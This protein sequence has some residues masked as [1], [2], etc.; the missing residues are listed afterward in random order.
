MNAST[1][2][3]DV[4]R[5]IEN[6]GVYITGSTVDKDGTV[7]IVSIDGKLYSTQLDRELSVDGFLDDFYVKMGP[8]K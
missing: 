5:M 4:R 6:S 3:G 1:I 7:I 2:R 8:L